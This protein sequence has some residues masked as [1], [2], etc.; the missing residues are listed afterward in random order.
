M[1]GKKEKSEVKQ[2]QS[3]YKYKYIKV[4]KRATGT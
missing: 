3:E 1:K 4:D 2:T